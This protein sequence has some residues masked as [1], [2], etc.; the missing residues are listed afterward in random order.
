MEITIMSEEE[1]YN[2]RQIERMFDEQSKD[3]K[4]HIDRAITPLTFQVTKT[5]GRVGILER[6]AWV[7]LGA[8]P[9]LT[10]WAGWLTFDYLNSKDVMKHDIQQAVDEAFDANIMR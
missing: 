3:I 2:N 1:R 8:I 7:S 9:L 5:N 10:V 4:D 6:M